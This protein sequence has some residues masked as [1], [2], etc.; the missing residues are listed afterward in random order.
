MFHER[1][2]QHLIPMITLL[3]E[4]C[5]ITVEKNLEVNI[6]AHLKTVVFCCLFLMVFTG[7]AL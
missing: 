1:L 4:R 7:A 2:I 6:F 5:G 3:Q